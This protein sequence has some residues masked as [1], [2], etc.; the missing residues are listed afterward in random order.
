[1]KAQPLTPPVHNQAS[2]YSNAEVRSIL[3]GL[4]F[5]EA[6]E[7]GADYPF[8][9]YNG[10]L[11]DRVTIAAIKAFQKRYHLKVTA[12]ADA[13]TQRTLEQTMKTLHQQLNDF[14]GSSLSIE[15]PTYDQR[16]ISVV[17][18]FQHGLGSAIQDGV[19]RLSDRQQLQKL[20]DAHA[21]VSN[22]MG[23]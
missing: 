13:R 6:P 4:G 12:R 23:N 1:M 5:T 15:H 8:T 7:V 16:T 10:A 18:I 14:M 22:N 11:S 20:S 17:R 9:S 19:I 21:R 3:N 2:I